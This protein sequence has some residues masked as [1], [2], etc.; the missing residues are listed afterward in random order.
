MAPCRW[1]NNEVRNKYA[2]IKIMSKSCCKYHSLRF[3][4]TYV[5]CSFIS[6]LTLSLLHVS[7]ICYFPLQPGKNC[8]KR[9]S[10]YVSLVYVNVYFHKKLI[11]AILNLNIF[12]MMDIECTAHWLLTL[13]KSMMHVSLC[14]N[15]MENAITTALDLWFQP[16]NFAMV[17]GNN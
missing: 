4:A 1:K 5:M 16:R 13:F 8:I 10:F 7:E 11:N 9:C 17:S 2:Q 14:H 3:K 12:T 15:N 6:H